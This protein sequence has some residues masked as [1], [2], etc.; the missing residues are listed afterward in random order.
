[1]QLADMCVLI[2]VIKEQTASLKSESNTGSEDGLT[3]ARE[4]ALVGP[5]SFICL[6]GPV[7]ACHEMAPLNFAAVTDWSSSC[8]QSES[9]KYFL[10]NLDR[11]GQLVSHRDDSLLASFPSS[12]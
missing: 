6:L 1:M 11:I 12:V 9:V 4:N 3:S 2:T 8:F 7:S 5:C 10:D